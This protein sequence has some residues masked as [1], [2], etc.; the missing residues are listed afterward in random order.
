MWVDDLFEVEEP[1]SLYEITDK[2][3]HKSL[4]IAVILQALLDLSKPKFKKEKSDIQIQRD[5]AHS[6][7]FASVGVTC[8]DFQEVCLYAGLKPE[9]VREVAYSLI[10]SKDNR[11]VRNTIKGFL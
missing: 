4:Y 1:D 8:K 9:S 7:V 5:Q 6:W 2:N 3:P 10:N 11:N